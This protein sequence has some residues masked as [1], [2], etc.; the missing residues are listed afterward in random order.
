MGHLVSHKRLLEVLKYEPLTGEWRWLI[1]VHG[2]G[3]IKRAGDI[4]GSAVSSRYLKIGIDGRRYY[5]RRLAV[6]YMTGRWPTRV[7][8]ANGDTLDCSWANLRE[9]TDSQNG[10]NSRRRADNTSGLKGV[11]WNRQAQKW[12]AEITVNQRKQIL[13]KSD[14]PAAAHFAYLTAADAAFGQFSRAA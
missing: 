12:Q 5:A 7:D 3:G 9:A 11:H 2:H 14:C 1:D 8:H 6:F 13:L 4:A 10:A